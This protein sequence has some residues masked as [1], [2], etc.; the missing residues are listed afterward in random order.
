VVFTYSVV[1]GGHFF[2]IVFHENVLVF[3][4]L[5]L[6]S[7]RDRILRLFFNLHIH[8]SQLRNPFYVHQ[9][10]HSFELF[11]NFGHGSR[12]LSY[13][14]YQKVSIGFETLKLFFLILLP[15]WLFSSSTLS[16]NYGIGLVFSSPTVLSRVS[17]DTLRDFFRA[18]SILL[19]IC[20][21]YLNQDFCISCL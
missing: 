14:S 10:I 4:R 18:S 8:L 15:S 2:A 5:L 6:R 16:L 3:N 12:S 17:K 1:K 11:Y 20:A 21:T 9:V 7:A 19:S 13:L